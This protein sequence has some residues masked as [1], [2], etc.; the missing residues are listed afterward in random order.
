[1]PEYLHPGVYIEETSYRGKPIQ[2]VS[3]STAGFVG[4]AR[5]GPVGKPVFVPSYAHFRRLFGEPLTTPADGLGGYLGHAVKAFFDNGGARCWVVRVLAA[6]ALQS[7]ATAERG[8]VLRLAPGVTVRGPTNTLRLNS[9]RGVAAG[10]VLRVFTRNDASSPFTLS[11][12]ATVQSHDATRGT[13]TVAAADAIPGG[14][15]LDPANTVILLNGALPADVAAVGG[16]AVFTARNPGVDGDSIAVE[17][18]PRDRAPVALASAGALRS[19]PLIDLEPLAFP[20]AVG[21]T[22]LQFTAGALRRLRVGDEIS[23][24]GSTGLTVQGIANG[25]LSFDIAG[26]SAGFDYT[27]G[28]NVSLVQRGATALPVPIALGAAPAAL[29]IDLT[30][31]GP[32]GP[33]AVPHEWAGLLRAGDTLEYSGGGNTTRVTLSAVRVAQ[34]IAAGAHVTLAGPGLTAAEAG[35]AEARI[36]RTSD[37]NPALARLFVGDASRFAAPAAAGSP[38][39][40]SVS[41][42]AAHDSARVLLVDTADNLLVVERAAGAFPTNVTIAGWTSMEQLQVAADGQTSVRVASTAGFYSGAKVELDSGAAKYEAVVQSVDPAARTITFAAGLALG[43]GVTVQ[44][45]ADPAARAAYLRVCEID[46]LVLEGGVVKETFEG[47]SWNADAATD[48]GLRYYATRINDAEAGSKLVTV[49]PPAGEA[50]TLAWAPAIAN[51]QARA[52][53]GGS[54]GSAL[55]ENDLIGSDNGPGRRTGIEA[56]GER[57]DIAMVAVPGVTA[58][59]VQGAL[60][61]HCERLKYRVAVL[62]APL[63]A[64]DVS[65]LQSHRN[66]YDSSYAAY[67]SPWVRALNSVTG[68]IESFPPSAYAMGIYARSDNTVGVHK[69]PANEVVR[70]ITDLVLPFTAAEQDVLNPVGINLIRDLTPRG[71]RVWGAR[72]LSSDPEWT[73]LNVRRLF[74]Y[75]EHS[76]DLG[77]QW[78]VF[79]PNSEALWARVVETINAFLFGVWKSGALMGTTPEEAYFITCDRTSMTQ[80]DIDNG[81]LVCL[82]GVAPVKPAEFVIFRIGQFTAKSA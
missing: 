49:A 19:N 9:L 20:L 8:S 70:N 13:V 56:L 29:A 10:T 25:D 38:E 58:E 45:A 55:T 42:G 2:G 66:N 44:L 82:I 4:A 40:V 37:T 50:H 65:T 51:G 5:K 31:A 67:Y 36:T 62:D 33:L 23:V 53:S 14:V 80:D 39:V 75:L 60:I 54:N 24:G 77:T 79:E 27:G 1:M 63:S 22:T 16:G 52:L 69:A 12:T 47:L 35:P 32:F 71:I 73:Y 64:I 30:A 72:T 78:V 46:V 18:R 3:T 41:N 43:A 15:A 34:Q 76:I 11:R 61:T 26:G 48:A 57:D 17:I 7:S 59:T 28:A 81:R 6:D 74:V 68:R 21:Q